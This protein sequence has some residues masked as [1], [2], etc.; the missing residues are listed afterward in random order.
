MGAVWILLKM[1]PFQMGRNKER[2]IKTSVPS[3]NAIYL[4]K[5]LGQPNRDN[6][7]K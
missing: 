3:R 5:V 1:V 6:L 7:G 2:E 4:Q